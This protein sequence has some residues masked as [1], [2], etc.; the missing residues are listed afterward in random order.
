MVVNEEEDFIDFKLNK[1]MVK[2]IG[3]VIGEIIGYI[4]NISG[5]FKKNGREMYDCYSIL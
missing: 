4:F 3:R 2:K 5:L 1:Y